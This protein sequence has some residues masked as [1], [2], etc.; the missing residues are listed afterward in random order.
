MAAIRV[1]HQVVYHSEHGDV[2]AWVIEYDEGHPSG[3][4]R[5]GGFTNQ[6]QKDA[7]GG[8]VFNLRSVY[9]EERGAFSTL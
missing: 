8:D 3:D 1:G 2:P 4:Y 7:G 9:G 6:A 5:L